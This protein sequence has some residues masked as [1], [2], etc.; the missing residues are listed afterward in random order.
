MEGRRCSDDGCNGDDE[1]GAVGAS[2]IGSSM[3]AI[4][5]LFDVKVETEKRL[6]GQWSD[7]AY[8]SKH[9]VWCAMGSEGGEG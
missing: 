5:I 8:T 7:W 6:F 1:G 4:F 2:R 3:A 9:N